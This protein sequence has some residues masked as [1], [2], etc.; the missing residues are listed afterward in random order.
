MFDN[1]QALEQVILVRVPLTLK[2]YQYILHHHHQHLSGSPSA[3]GSFIITTIIP[4]HN[5]PSFQDA[6]V[7][8]LVHLQHR[9]AR[10][11]PQLTHRGNGFT[12]RTDD[13]F[14]VGHLNVHKDVL[15]RRC[16][17]KLGLW[18][19]ICII[20]HIYIINVYIYIQLISVYIYIHAV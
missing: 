10:L 7:G 5:Q 14:D 11:Q 9:H 13:L 1:F 2:T 3:H 6:N 12:V 16:S 4:H 19:H 8:S 17:N 18:Y 20:V 15:A